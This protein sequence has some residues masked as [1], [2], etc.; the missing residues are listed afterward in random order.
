MQDP[1]DAPEDTPERDHEGAALLALLESL[2][3]VTSW[4]DTYHSNA[5]AAGPKRPTRCCREI[6][7]LLP[8]N[9]RQHRTLN[10]QKDVLPYALC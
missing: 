9:Q 3:Q 10:I 4:L 6:G 8:N 7:I 5:V 1:T 2:L